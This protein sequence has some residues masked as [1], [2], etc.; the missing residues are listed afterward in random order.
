MYNAVRTLEPPMPRTVRVILLFIFVAFCA[1][2][3]K[4][5]DYPPPPSDPAE[6]LRRMEEYNAS[7]PKGED[8]PSEEPPAASLEAQ[9]AAA[10]H[11][12]ARYRGECAEAEK[13]YLRSRAVWMDDELFL[14]E[15]PDPA[16][17]SADD[18]IKSHVAS[19]AALLAAGARAQQAGLLLERNLIVLK[20]IEDE[21]EQK[22]LD[23]S[24][25]VTL[26]VS[27]EAGERV[28]SADEEEEVV[29]PT[30]PSQ[31][32]GACY[33]ERYPAPRMVN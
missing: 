6:V 13:D 31:F 32:F 25:G 28:P 8:P 22:K 5:E 4:A 33:P 12:V 14:V 18:V 29:F 19:R 30:L 2:P 21:I 9:R 15:P 16:M 17:M 20:G 24:G 11:Y 23:A 26:R 27:A 7:H 1:A 3:A 10:A